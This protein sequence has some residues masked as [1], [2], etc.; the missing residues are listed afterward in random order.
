[1]CLTENSML[2]W[3][4][5]SCQV[6][7]ATALALVDVMGPSLSDSRSPPPAGGHAGEGAPRFAGGL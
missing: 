1:M 6:D 7:V 3:L 4:G 2:E 5:S